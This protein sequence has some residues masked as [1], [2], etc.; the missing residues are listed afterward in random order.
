M[1]YKINLSLT[2]TG[3]V[4]II[5]SLFFCFFFYFCFFFFQQLF[6]NTVTWR[7]TSCLRIGA[8]TSLQL[9][10]LLIQR[11]FYSLRTILSV[12]MIFRVQL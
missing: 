10:E 11:D 2:R 1:Y 4:I 3:A 7:V 6:I 12:A 9:G 5:V 8:K